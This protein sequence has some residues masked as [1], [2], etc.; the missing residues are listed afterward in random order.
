ME[1][2]DEAL[3][4]AET[5]AREGQWNGAVNRLYYACFYGVNAV[6][7]T[8][9]L[10][11]S[12]HAGVRSLFN[13][14]LVNPGEVSAESGVLYNALFERRMECDYEDFAQAEADEVLAWLPAAQRMLDEL[15]AIVDKE[16]KTN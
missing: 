2:A 10:H 4:Q 1:R 8:R 15:R 3:A 5:L 12:R 13:Q 7:Y 14:H 16:T 6:L 11:R 9:G